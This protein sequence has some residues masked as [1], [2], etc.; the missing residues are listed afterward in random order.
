MIQEWMLVNDKWRLWMKFG[1]DYRFAPPVIRRDE[2]TSTFSLVPIFANPGVAAQL[3]IPF[4]V[5]LH[6]LNRDD[7]DVNG[8]YSFEVVT[9]LGGSNPKL[10]HL[11]LLAI[12]S[13]DKETFDVLLSHPDVDLN[14]TAYT[15]DNARTC[16]L[17]QAAAIYNNESR[18]LA[19]YF[20]RRIASHPTVDMNAETFCAAGETKLAPLQWLIMYYT[21]DTFPSPPQW[22]LEAFIEAG[23]NIHLESDVWYSPYELALRRSKNMSGRHTD[24][25]IACYLEALA[26]M[27]EWPASIKINGLA[28]GFLA[29]RRLVATAQR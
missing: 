16:S 11:L 2:N 21:E 29:R 22:A 13:N 7:F 25:D 12:I 4:L 1:G 9:P 6:R 5:N 15:Y 18:E 26:V 20:L 27:R 19:S 14:S 10:V 17:F 28:R 24:E 3:G 8:L 23:A